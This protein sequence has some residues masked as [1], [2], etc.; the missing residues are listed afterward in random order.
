MASVSST[1]IILKF[2]QAI[3][4]TCSPPECLSN[5]CHRQKTA[6]SPTAWQGHFCGYTGKALQDSLP[7]T[8]HVDTMG[9][10]VAEIQTR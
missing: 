5:L 9:L 4:Y 7:K 2:C 3:F 8:S 10:A 6:G 1:S